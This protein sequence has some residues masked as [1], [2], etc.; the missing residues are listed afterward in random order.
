MQPSYFEYLLEQME[1][2][3]LQIRNSYQNPADRLEHPFEKG[4]MF[5]SFY[6]TGKLLFIIGGFQTSWILFVFPVTLNFQ[7]VMVVWYMI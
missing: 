1:R 3:L 7:A 4:W 5:I 6:G 2:D